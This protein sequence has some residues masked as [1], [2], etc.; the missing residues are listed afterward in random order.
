[1]AQFWRVDRFQHVISTPDDRHVHDTNSSGS[2]VSGGVSNK[3]SVQLP[4]ATGIS[5]NELGEAIL[6]C[7]PPPVI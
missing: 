6:S 7:S 4:A 1:M 5:V 2:R 3:R